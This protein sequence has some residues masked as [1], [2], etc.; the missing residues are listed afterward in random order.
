MNPASFPSNPLP[1]PFMTGFGPKQ[2][3]ATRPRAFKTQLAWINGQ[4][5]PFDPANAPLL[6]P[7]RQ[8]GATVSARIRG[9]ATSR[10]PAVFRLHEQMARFWHSAQALG[11]GE[12]RFTLEQ[13]CQAVF[14]VIE[15]NGL[16]DCVVRPQLFAS[17]DSHEPTITIDAWPCEPFLGAE[18]RMSTQTRRSESPLLQA[19]TNSDAAIMLD[20]DG[21]VSAWTSG[22][23]FLVRDNVL[24]AP[25]GPTHDGVMRD[26]VF[27]LAHDG[28]YQVASR[29]LSREALLAADELFVC[30]PMADV[31]AVTR[32]DDRLIGQGKMGRV[33]QKMQAML[34]DTV[35]GRNRRSLYWLEYVV[36]Q[37][38]F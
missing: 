33:T 5:I 18:V 20:P 16:S 28:G 37:P 24:Y 15:G 21:F 17:A 23:L 26:T 11:L 29:R 7:T 22:T 1:R 10:G 19:K 6:N 4:M 2:S 30:G 38:V 32:V 27:S 8:D 12:P 3:L 9:Y 34:D 31:M 14:G 25:D 35:R 36:T 13:L